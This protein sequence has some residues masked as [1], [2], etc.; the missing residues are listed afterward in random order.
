MIKKIENAGINID[1]RATVNQR[2]VKRPK[3]QLIPRKLNSEHNKK[4]RIIFQT[5]AS[6]LLQAEQRIQLRP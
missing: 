2:Q 6:R 3:P 1:R 5:R 4:L